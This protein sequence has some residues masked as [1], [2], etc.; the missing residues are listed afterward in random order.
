MTPCWWYIDVS[1][2]RGCSPPDLVKWTIFGQYICFGGK[3]LLI[4]PCNFGKSSRA[5]NPLISP[6]SDAVRRHLKVTGGIF[7]KLA[8]ALPPPPIEIGPI[9]RCGG[10]AQEYFIGTSQLVSG[11]SQEIGCKSRIQICPSTTGNNS[12]N[13][14]LLIEQVNNS[15]F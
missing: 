5:K 8:S 4:S 15:I 10:M 1:G 3:L 6:S 14:Q 12:R 9:C 7:G 13:F 2:G 11:V